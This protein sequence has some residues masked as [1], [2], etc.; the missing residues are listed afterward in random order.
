[1]IFALKNNGY[2]TLYTSLTHL[3]IPHS[4][5]YDGFSVRCVLL[6]VPQYNLVCYGCK[7]FSWAWPFLWNALL[8]ELSLI[9]LMDVFNAR[10]KMH[11]FKL[12]FN[13]YC[14]RVLE[15]I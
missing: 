14:D 3:I 9:T 15:H 5:A 7:S 6:T 10:I 13:V 12:A 2:G 11:Y 8:K 4:E 1:M